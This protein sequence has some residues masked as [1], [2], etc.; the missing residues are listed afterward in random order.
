MGAHGKPCGIALWVQPVRGGAARTN[1]CSVT[2]PQR[3]EV[4]FSQA[5]PNSLSVQGTSSEFEVVPADDQT[6]PP[7]SGGHARNTKVSGWRVLAHPTSPLCF[8]HLALAERHRIAHIPGALWSHLGI[9]KG[10]GQG[11]LLAHICKFLADDFPDWG[12]TGTRPLR[13]PGQAASPAGLG[14]VLSTSTYCE[15]ASGPVGS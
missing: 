1:S 9:H 7:A 13:K 11:A 8:G 10:L 4:V 12:H 2:R 5:V 14:P 3:G 15:S 6:S